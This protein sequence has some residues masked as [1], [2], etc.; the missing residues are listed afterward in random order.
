MGQKQSEELACVEVDQ[1]P[2]ESSSKLLWRVKDSV[3]DADYLALL[4]SAAEKSGQFS[5][6]ACS[7]C[8]G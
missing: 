3:P 4:Y 6:K 5:V 2:G 8:S 7:R 1:Q